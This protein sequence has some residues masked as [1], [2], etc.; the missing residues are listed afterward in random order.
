VIVPQQTAYTQGVSVLLVDDPPCVTGSA[1]ADS[2]GTATFTCDPVDSPYFW[3]VERMTSYVIGTVPSGALLLIYEG[4]TMT[5]LQIRDGTSSPSFDVAD[6]MS[7]ITIHPN[8]QMIAQWT[9]L[10]PGTTAYI[11]IQHQLWRRIIPGN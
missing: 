9:G 4:P 3:R 5:P 6:E 1:V 10:T 11:S 2:T 8:C 7:P